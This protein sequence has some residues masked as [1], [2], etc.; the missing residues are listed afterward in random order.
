[1]TNSRRKWA[2]FLSRWAILL[3][4]VVCPL[5]SVAQEWPTRPVRIVNTFAAGGTA[6][7]LARTV[8]DHLSSAFG[9]QFFVETR[10]GAGGA[11]GVQSVVNS[12][13]DGYNFVI[14]NVSLL[15]LA[16]IVNPKLG[17]DPQ[18]DL[19]NIAYIAGAPI[20]LS[21]NPAAGIGTLD[22]FI[23]AAK[24]RERPM[25][26]SSS[27]LGSMVHLVAEFFAQKAGIRVEHVPYKGASQ[28]LMDLVGRHIDFACQTVSSTSAQLRS[29]QLI[30]LAQTAAERIEA[31]PDLPTFRELGF[32]D[33]VSTTWFSLSGPA[34]LAPDIT[35]KVNREVGRA[36]SKAEAR[37]RV[38]LDGMV[39]DAMTAQEF[40]RFM[41]AETARWKPVA[42]RAGVIQR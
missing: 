33:L 18:R 22:A 7:V 12:P 27:G 13:P 21:L 9:Q 35:Q 26:Y 29:G 32:P 16:P 1:V 5:S 25:T 31:Y 8:A 2:A 19:T 37:E 28:G 36:M 20:V 11:I 10:A 3:S 41:A 6:D 39:T 34:G 24:K 38:Q 15:V 42:E 4:S 23:A 17:Y 40:L 30:G 14:T